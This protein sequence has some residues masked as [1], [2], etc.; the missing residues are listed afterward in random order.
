MIRRFQTP[1]GI[2]NVFKTDSAFVRTFS[3]GLAWEYELIK[4]VIDYMPETGTILDI[5]GHIGTHAI[6]YALNRPRAKVITFEPQ[7]KIR[8][9][10]E[11][12]KIENAASSLEIKPFGIGHTESCVHLAADFTSD[13]Y[14]KDITVNYD[15]HHSVNFGGLGITN[16]PRGEKVEIRTVDSMGLTDVIYMKIDVEGAE[17]LAVFGAQN[18]IKMCR[19][20]LLIEQSD[21]NLTKCY[22]DSCPALK[23]FCVSTFLSDLGYKKQDLGD[24]NYLYTL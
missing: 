9:L 7:S 10:L 15:G 5:G 13:G 18:T 8:E 22:I 11:S 3:S 2:F 24:A 6:P 4:K 19:P 17:T 23:E 20:V 21:K 12:N 16:D 1:N 14:S